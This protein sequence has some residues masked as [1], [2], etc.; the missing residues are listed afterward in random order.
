[1]P[2]NDDKR[3]AKPQR[4][5]GTSTAFGVDRQGRRNL[6]VALGSK[7]PDKDSAAPYPKK[8]KPKP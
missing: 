8:S 6:D 5:E 7:Q 3:P 4:R 2:D 1:M